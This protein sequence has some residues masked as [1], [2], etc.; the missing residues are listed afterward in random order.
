MVPQTLDWTCAG[1][2]GGAA[3]GGGAEAVGAGVTGCVLGAAWGEPDGLTAGVGDDRPLG[4]GGPE[5]EAAGEA[6]LTSRT[7]ATETSPAN[8]PLN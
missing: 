1:V 6:Q 8:A 5:C 7:T 2:G 4:L 3:G